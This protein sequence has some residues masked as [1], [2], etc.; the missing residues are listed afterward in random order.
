MNLNIDVRT[1]IIFVGI[2]N[3]I[4]IIIL[5]LHY[6]INKTSKVFGWWIISSLFTMMGYLSLVI[7]DNSSLLKILILVGNVFLILAAFFLYIG[8]LRFF[9]KQENRSLLATIMTAF[10]L[11]FSYYIFID[12]N[13]AA[14]IML[15]SFFSIIILWMMIHCLWVNKTKATRLTAN[16]TAMILFIYVLLTIYRVITTINSASFTN[17]FIP[18]ASNVLL[19]LFSSIEPIFITLSLILMVNQKLTEDNKDNTEMIEKIFNTSPDPT[20]V[21]HLESDQ[22]IMVNDGLTKIYGIKREEAIGKTTKEL[23]LWKNSDDYQAMITMLKEKGPCENF[24][25]EFLTKDGKQIIGLAS[26]KLMHLH[27]GEYVVASLRNITKLKNYE[28]ERSEI[29]AKLFYTEKLAAIGTL[30]AGVAH[31]INNPLT[32]IIGNADIIENRYRLLDENSSIKSF[33]AIQNA[34]ERITAVINGLR[35]YAIPDSDQTEK[36]N[37]HELIK[38]T[39]HFLEGIYRRD[40]M[41]IETQLTASNH[42]VQ[43]NKG[44]IHQVLLNLLVNAKDAIEDKRS[45]EPTY[46]GRIKIITAD[47]NEHLQIEIS[48]N[49]SGI[50]PDIIPRLFDPFVT[51]KSP[52]KGTGLGLS[53]CQ[54]IIKSFSGTI[55]VNSEKG[56][57]TSFEILIP[58]S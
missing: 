22:I 10:I 53:I 8:I 33:H 21:A 30:A 34:I 17:M 15:I 26:A 27:N 36:V 41:A 35:A 4:R 38:E 16:F 13:I 51:T 46:A 3:L 9:N 44:K 31:E 7:R 23:H 40:N 39:L 11:P 18:S 50:S 14:R 37:I 57:G 55:S 52:G 2:N 19:F 5:S 45:K 43:A 32:I 12:D 28:K 24:E 1:L 49:G 6:Y 56:V 58:K 25:S 20:V 54:T 48:D 47:S 29:Q 42:F